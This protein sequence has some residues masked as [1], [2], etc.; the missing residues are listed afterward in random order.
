MVTLGEVLLEE[1]DFAGVEVEA[2]V[3]DARE[4]LEGVPR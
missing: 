1:G 4:D 3:L 2:R